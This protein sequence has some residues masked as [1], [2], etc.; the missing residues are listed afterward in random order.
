MTITIGALKASHNRT[1]F[2]DHKHC[3]TGGMLLVCHVI[4]QDH[5]IK[6]SSDFTGRNPSRQAIVLPSLVAIGR[7]VILVF[8]CHTTLQNQVI[9]ELNDFMVRNPSR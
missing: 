5:A 6:E 9:K 8:V 4:S 2:G 3:G 1:K 7:G